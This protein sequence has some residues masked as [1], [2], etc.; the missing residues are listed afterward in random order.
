MKECSKC[1]EKKPLSEFNRNGKY[2]R[3][4]CKNCCSISRK[5]RDA[6][7]P[8]AKQ[9][10]GRKYR[11]LN[12]ERIKEKNHR[13]YIANKE[14]WLANNRRWKTENK[15]KI[16][17]DW[18]KY[19][20]ENA[21][22]IKEKNFKYRI[23][24]ADKVKAGILRWN[25][26]NPEKVKAKQRR[27]AMKRRATLKGRLN[28]IMSSGICRSLDKGKAGRHWESLVDYTVD[29]LKRHLERQF[30]PGM[31][32]DNYGQWHI[33]HIIPISVHNYISPD[34]IDFKRCWSLHNLQPLWATENMIKKDRLIK[35]FQPAL[36]I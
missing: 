4:D 18:K 9:V 20:S 12:K 5:G 15:E 25:S 17:E 34:D 7:N 1:G 24:N 13:R 35:P 27:A 33:D 28:N 6:A 36:A 10:R 23:A 30:L 16:K 21:E 14:K 32:W 19:R 8:D 3:G 26:N 31:S 29:K 22:Q 11:Q 2:I